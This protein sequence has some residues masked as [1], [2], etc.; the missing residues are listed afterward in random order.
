MKT[1]KQLKNQFSL[2]EDTNSN[3]PKHKHLKMFDKTHKK[4]AKWG[5]DFKSIVLSGKKDIETDIKKRCDPL[6]K[7]Y[8]TTYDID[9]KTSG[10]FVGEDKATRKCYSYVH[11]AMKITFQKSIGEQELRNA[12]N[13]KGKD[14]IYVT[15]NWISIEQ[16]VS[17]EIESN[18][19]TTFK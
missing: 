9:Y 2:N 6:A 19:S 3:H 5:K 12:F 14:F 13:V 11:Y 4:L 16:M 10:Y 7:K 15:D 17:E 8:N 1:Y 18:Y